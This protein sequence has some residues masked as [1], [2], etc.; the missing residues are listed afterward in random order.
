MAAHC[1]I[2]ASAGI[3]RGCCACKQRGDQKS[4]QGSFHMRSIVVCL[5]AGLVLS[6]AHVSSAGPPG[7]GQGGKG[8]NG[9]GFEGNS[10]GPQG[11]GGQGFGGHGGPGGQKGP[12][13]QGGPQGQNG[14]GP[15]AMLQQI[16]SLDANG[17]GALT[18]AEVTDARLQQM[19]KQ[20]DTD[21]SGSVTREELIAAMSN[22]GGGPRGGGPGAGGQGGGGHGGP[23][24]PG[25]ILPGFVQDQLQLTD[26]Q[27]QQLA[28]LQA[29][30]DA[31]LAQILTAQQIQHLTAGP[32]MGGSGGG[33]Q[34]SNQNGSGSSRSK[35]GRS[36]RNNK[37]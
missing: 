23:P 34:N 25:E 19:L 15:E 5:C 13:G 4:N 36:G 11:K 27:R 12:P 17:D 7:G 35:S 14:G 16:M 6:L 30:V 2:R 22:Q 9:Q 8:G 29:Q 24:R 37:Q 3:L 33:Q 31:Q 21:S 28:A 32:P 18:P 20:A 10:D 1:E 26:S